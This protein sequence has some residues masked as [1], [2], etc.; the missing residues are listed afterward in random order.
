MK[1]PIHLL[2]LLPAVGCS[3]LGNS[4]DTWLFRAPAAPTECSGGLSA[5]NFLD[6][7]VPEEDV[8]E[9]DWTIEESVEE[10]DELFFAQIYKGT[11]GER[12]LVLDGG[13]YVGTETDGQWAFTWDRFEEGATES[14]HQAGY[15]FSAVGGSHETTTLVFTTKKGVLTGTWSTQTVDDIRYTESDEWEAA[16]VGVFDSSIPSDAYLVD[17]DGMPIRNEFDSTD[18]EDAV[19]FLEVTATCETSTPVTA[20]QVHY[21]DDFESLGAGQQPGVD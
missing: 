6:A 19:C 1:S 12:V 20:T 17:A 18:C 8:V 2:A 15:Q 21:E 9:S 3:A 16:E 11:A 14:E 13:V 4:E 7:D 10:S 5:H